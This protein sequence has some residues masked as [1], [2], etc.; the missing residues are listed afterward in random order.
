MRQICSSAPTDGAD[1]QIARRHLRRSIMREIL[2]ATCLATY[3]TEQILSAKL[4]AFTSSMSKKCQLKSC[5]ICNLDSKGLRA[6][7]AEL[8]VSRRPYCSCSTRSPLVGDF[9]MRGSCCGSRTRW[10]CGGESKAP[11]LIA[12]GTSNQYGT[13]CIRM[14]RYIYHI[15]T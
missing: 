7:H 8:C 4:S 6:F 2:L 13:E 11:S 1:P 14:Y 9:I 10:R 15:Y 5:K 12:R 3:D